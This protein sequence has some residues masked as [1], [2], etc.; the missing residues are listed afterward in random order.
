[1]FEYLIFK[2]SFKI[3]GKKKNVNHDTNHQISD[4]F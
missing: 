2:A 1:M 4:E 3:L